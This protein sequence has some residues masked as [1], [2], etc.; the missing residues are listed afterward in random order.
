MEQANALAAGDLDNSMFDGSHEAANDGILAGSI[1]LVRENLK[2]L[3]G[4]APN[5]LSQAAGEG[6]LGVRSDASRHQ[7]AYRKVVEGINQTLDIIVETARDY[8]GERRH[9]SVVFPRK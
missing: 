9:V 4:A 5:E 2:R 7:G 1:G 3:N 8:G 6:K